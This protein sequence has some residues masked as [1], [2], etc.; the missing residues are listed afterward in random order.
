MGD[1]GTET[2]RCLDAHLPQTKHLLYCTDF[3]PPYGVIFEKRNSWQGKAYT[4][5]I[6]IPNNRLRCS[7][8]RLRRKTQCY[9]KKLG[10]LAASIF[11]YLLFK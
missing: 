3:W 10:N 2:A 7:L 9:T 6:E 4:F 11:L 5:T 8:A 1:R